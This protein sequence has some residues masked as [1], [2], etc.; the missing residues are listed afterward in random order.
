MRAI[1]QKHI[2]WVIFSALLFQLGSY[3]LLGY[4]FVT[5]QVRQIELMSNLGLLFSA[6]QSSIIWSIRCIRRG[7][8]TMRCYFSVQ[9]AIILSKF[10]HW[11]IRQDL[12]KHRSSAL[13]VV[14]TVKEGVHWL[15]VQH[16]VIHA[17]MLSILCVTSWIYCVVGF[18]SSTSKCLDRDS[19]SSLCF[20]WNKNWPV[21]Y[22]LILTL[23]S[24]VDNFVYTSVNKPVLC[25]DK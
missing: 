24:S 18:G 7:S 17:I 19:F 11:S 3:S 4:H 9:I 5:Q 16:A 25:V 12:Q 2:V 8:R 10:W 13:A 6:Q 15:L 14:L 23:W 22:R 21:I 1:I 20:T